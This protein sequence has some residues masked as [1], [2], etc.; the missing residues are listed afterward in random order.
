MGKDGGG[1]VNETDA[2]A[3][4]A[5]G[6]CENCGVADGAGIDGAATG[7]DGLAGGTPPPDSTKQSHSQKNSSKSLNKCSLKDKVNRINKPNLISQLLNFK[8]TFK[9][10]A[11]TANS[12]YY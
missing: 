9:K 4:R 8:I 11:E 10:M 6:G 3:G 12:E 1:Q 2:E 5:G 7:V